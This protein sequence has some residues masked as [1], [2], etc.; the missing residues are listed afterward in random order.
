MA[1]EGSTWVKIGLA[2]EQ[3]QI[4]TFKHGQHQLCVMNTDDGFHAVD[5]RCPHEGYPLASGDLKGC[6]LTCAWHNWKFDAR[7]GECTLGG[8]DV[9]VYPTRIGDDGT[10]EVDLADPDPATLIP[11]LLRSVRE[12]LLEHDNGRVIR[13]AVRLIQAGYSAADLLAFVAG[14]DAD[15]AQY[16]STHVLALAADCG[17]LLSRY[18]GPEALYAVAPVL[19][20]AGESQ[21]NRPART[22]A[23]PES[24]G[25]LESFRAAVEGEDGP[26]AES[27][28]LGAL[29]GDGGV[30]VAE[31]WLAD[32]VFRHFL[33]FGHS[34]IYLLKTRE[35]LTRS[36]DAL[37]FA[38][39]I[40]PGLLFKIVLG[41][42]EDTLPYMR[43]W[44]EGVDDAAMD[45]LASLERPDV[46]L[47]HGAL[48]D[49]MLDGGFADARAAIWR[50]LERGVSRDQLANELVVAAAQRM[51]RFD[52]RLEFDAGVAENWLWAT[53]RLTFASAA[54]QLLV[55]W[56]SPQALRLL[57][58]AAAFIHTGRAM[59][60]PE[61]SLPPTLTAGGPDAV[62]AAVKDRDAD[63]AVGLLRGLA[64]RRESLAQ[65]EIVLQDLALSDPV[66]RPIVV[67]H[68]IKT[69][70]AGFDEWRALEGNPDRL[71]PLYAALR[72][73]ASPV[74]ERR[75]RDQVETSIAWVAEG[76]MPRK[77]TQ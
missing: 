75:V 68:V 13:D 27:L 39:S 43:A 28:L 6:V 61:C 26:R 2:C 8:E 31:E 72:F 55:A 76:R 69:L 63:R 15:R 4:S 46:D 42:R 59:D 29:D 22:L 47:D 7:S 67:T 37:A 65:L 48:R 20:L 33:D 38:R 36:S 51:W 53:H 25:T 73:I 24:G 18:R 62:V 34:A 5:N 16:G 56:R 54:R 60:A 52:L 9:R 10:L 74:K 41:T 77:L 40:M 30:D 1:L 32:A 3:P 23:P 58:Q 11:P 50:E 57:F 21:K 49:V 71:W 35:V 66:V 70:L 45:R 14:F 64:A 19:D 17:R 44:F 12:G